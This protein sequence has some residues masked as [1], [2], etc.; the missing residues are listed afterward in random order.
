MTSRLPFTRAGIRRAVNAAK[1]AGLTVKEIRPDGTVVV[2]DGDK[3]APAV[4][5]GAAN[6]H[7]GRPSS[8]WED[9]GA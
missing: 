5:N 7:T 3:P 1:D 9:A 6:G 8:K 2:Q 4:Q